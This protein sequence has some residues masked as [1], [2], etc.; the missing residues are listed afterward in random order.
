MLIEGVFRRVIK[1]K[2]I[3]DFEELAQIGKDWKA[4]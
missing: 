4:E 3:A 2:D 1:R